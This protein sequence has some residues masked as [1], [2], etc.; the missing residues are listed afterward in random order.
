MEQDLR[1]C[2]MQRAFRDSPKFYLIN[3]EPNLNEPQY[4]CYSA[5]YLQG[6]QLHQ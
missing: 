2:E 3:D 5:P 4:I 6:G 1:T